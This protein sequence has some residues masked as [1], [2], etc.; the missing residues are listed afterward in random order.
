MQQKTCNY[1]ELFGS[2]TRD[3][4]GRR[5]IYQFHVV[6]LNWFFH[7]ALQLLEADELPAGQDIVF[8]WK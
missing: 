5:R 2:S 7:G 3:R 1:I 8:I 6:E 4:H